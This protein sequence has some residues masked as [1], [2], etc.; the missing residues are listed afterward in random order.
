MRTT[1]DLPANLLRQ[2][3]V[4]AALD[5]TTLK[6]L[7]AW[8]LERGLREKTGPLTAESAR[9]SRSQLPVVRISGDRP[10]PVYSNAELQDLLDREEI[11]ELGR[12]H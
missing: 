9:Q 3:K 7:V 1:I 2:A 8:C 11:I 5:G 12:Q 10:L 6:E 4:R